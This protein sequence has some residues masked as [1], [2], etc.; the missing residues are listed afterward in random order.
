MIDLVKQLKE[1]IY[2]D[3]IQLATA[4]RDV[5][6]GGARFLAKISWNEWKWTFIEPDYENLD[7]HLE[8]KTLN[9]S[10]H[11][12]FEQS[13]VIATKKGTIIR[14]EISHPFDGGFFY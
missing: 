7:Q 6:R 5:N 13:N 9:M 10:R 2:F 14:I 12:L 8:T 4:W 1:V 3:L 11:Y